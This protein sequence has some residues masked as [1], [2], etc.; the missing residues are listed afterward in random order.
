MTLW[1]C[2]IHKPMSDD[3]T[4]QDGSSSRDIT[5]Y[6]TADMLTQAV[7]AVILVY[8]VLKTIEIA[9]NIPIPVI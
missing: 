7:V 3:D 4:Q 9:L 1:T 8:L 5:D 6:G 2:E